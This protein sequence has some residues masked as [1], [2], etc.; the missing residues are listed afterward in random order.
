[1]LPLVFFL[2]CLCFCFCFCPLFLEVFG[3]PADT[4][5]LRYLAT[6]SWKRRPYAAENQNQ[7]A[8][9][10]LFPQNC[11]YFI[12]D[13]VSLVGFHSCCS[14]SAR[15]TGQNP[16]IKPGP[17][18]TRP[19]PGVASWLHIYCTKIE[20]ESLVKLKLQ[21]KLAENK[22]LAQAKVKSEMEHTPSSPSTNPLALPKYSLWP[23]QLPF[24][25][26]KWNH[27]SQHVGSKW[28]T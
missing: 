1:M 13:P 3:G 2:F 8:A 24:A 4:Q 21:R 22:N 26:C 11:I 9:A 18:E 23:F 25:E 7:T 16:M 5:I 19:A 28:K 27:Q 10:F 17:V 15:C 14:R 6:D 12:I 20:S